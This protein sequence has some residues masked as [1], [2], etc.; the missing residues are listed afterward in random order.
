MAHRWKNTL[1][2]QNVTPEGAYLNRRAVM[3]GL[4]GMGLAGVVTP[5]QAEALEANPWEDITQYNNFYEFGTGKGDP[6]KHAQHHLVGIS[7]QGNRQQPHS[8]QQ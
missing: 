7:S 6:A 1:T 4:A 2:N 5:A 3:A 8:Q